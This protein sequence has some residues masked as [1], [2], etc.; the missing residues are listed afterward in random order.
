MKFLRITWYKRRVYFLAVCRLKTVLPLF[1]HSLVSGP[2][3]E[4]L[5]PE[6]PVKEGTLGRVLC[7]G[8]F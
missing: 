4:F 5:E 6:N 3:A 7:H 2:T 8:A 1:R